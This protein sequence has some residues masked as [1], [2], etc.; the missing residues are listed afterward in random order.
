MLGEN[1]IILTALCAYTPCQSPEESL[2]SSPKQCKAQ[3]M[4]LT[5]SACKIPQS[6]LTKTGPLFPPPA[7]KM[8]ALQSEVTSAARP[9]PLPPRLTALLPEASRCSP[10][11]KGQAL[12]PQNT[13]WVLP[14]PPPGARAPG[15][16]SGWRIPGSSR[17]T[18][19]TGSGWGSGA[20][21]TGSRSPRRAGVSRGCRDTSAGR[22]AGRSAAARLRPSQRFPAWR[23][24]GPRSPPLPGAHAQPG[25]NAR[26]KWDH[27][28]QGNASTPGGAGTPQKDTLPALRGG[29]AGRGAGCEGK[30]SRRRDPSPAPHGGPVTWMARPRGAAAGPPTSLQ[31][32]SGRPPPPAAASPQVAVAQM[33]AA[34]ARLKYG[35][36]RLSPI[37]REPGGS[38]CAGQRVRSGGRSAQRS[39]E[40]GAAAILRRALPS[41][42]PGRPYSCGGRAGRAGRRWEEAGGCPRS[43]RASLSAVRGLG[44]GETRCSPGAGRRAERG[45]G[46]SGPRPPGR[47][48]VRGGAGEG[49]GREGKGLRAGGV[50]PGVC[51][52]AQLCGH[53]ER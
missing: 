12:R 44:R 22:G 23:P 20:G 37:P 49:K 47:A 53:A 14:K 11:T 19:G 34:A 42:P 5:F 46:R 31:Y 43:A 50:A 41:P 21:G 6:H 28:P 38:G 7:G 52:D 30:R 32:S 45:A 16:T 18:A 48:G 25:E 33:L 4:S 2:A 17:S 9:H 36:W 13:A 39:G 8:P 27:A 51:P 35:G 3:T 15:G 1:V 24:A 26:E 29:G 40:P 10:R